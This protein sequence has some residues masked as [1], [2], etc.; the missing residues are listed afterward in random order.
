MTRPFLSEGGDLVINAGCG[1]D[2]SIKA[3]VVDEERRPIPGLGTE[4]CLPVSSDGV[5]QKITWKS[6]KKLPK[7][8]VSLYFFIRDAELFTFRIAEEVH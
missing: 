6:D 8:M 1:Q 7:G 4:D 3:A 2:G 5:S